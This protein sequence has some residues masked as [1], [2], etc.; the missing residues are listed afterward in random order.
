MT[1]PLAE[2]ESGGISG[3]VSLE[4]LAQ[5]KT[6]I[7]MGPGMGRHPDTEALVR[8]AADALDQPL[9]IDADALHPI[10]GNGKV[11]VLTPH[12]VRWLY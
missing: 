3:D 7:A 8:R 11:R 1:E 5:G 12:L 6:V 2:N 10:R 4:R 9:V